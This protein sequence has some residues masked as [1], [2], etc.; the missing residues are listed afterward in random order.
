M[1]MQ[2]LLEGTVPQVVVYIWE[3]AARSKYGHCAIE[4]QLDSERS[5]YIS[6][7]PENFVTDTASCRDTFNNL[8]LLWSD[9]GTLTAKSED[10]SEP[11]RIRKISL[12]GLGLNIKKM[13]HAACLFRAEIE[14]TSPRLFWGLGPGRKTCASLVLKIL[15]KGGL[16]SLIPTYGRYGHPYHLLLLSLRAP[17]A[18][19]ATAPIIYTDMVLEKNPSL[20]LSILSALT[21]TI[22]IILLSIL[23]KRGLHRCLPFLSNRVYRERSLVEIANADIIIQAITAMTMG[24]IGMAFREELA[25]DSEKSHWRMPIVLYF[26]LWTFSAMV[27]LLAVGFVSSKFLY[28]CFGLNSVVR[29][30]GLS[31]LTNY[32]KK[33][34]DLDKK[35]LKLVFYKEI[36]LHI[37]TIIG[38]LGSYLARRFFYNPYEYFFIGTIGSILLGYVLSK[39]SIYVLNRK[40]F[41]HLRAMRQHKSEEIRAILETHSPKPEQFALTCFTTSSGIIFA[42]MLAELISPSI[43]EIEALFGMLGSIVGYISGQF[44]YDRSPY[45]LSHCSRIC[46]FHSQKKMKESQDN[47]SDADYSEFLSGEGLT[48]S[49]TPSSVPV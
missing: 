34:E 21:M 41:F 17:I 20:Y 7:V 9:R 16:K 19:A 31:R 33:I 14:A 15:E 35:L 37:I 1:R 5:E 12:A 45:V 30:S 6:F 39:I 29:P 42:L 40:E 36:S 26:S 4:I 38:A 23:D 25:H 3:D 11:Y 27:G 22:S 8:R 49:D 24:I 46:L 43:M 44:V 47:A 48:R 18:I 28:F 32:L 10:L 13:Y 2:F